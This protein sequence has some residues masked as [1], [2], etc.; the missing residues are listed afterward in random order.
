M[1]EILGEHSEKFI[2]LG[3]ILSKGNVGKKSGAETER[4]AIQRPLHLGIHPICRHQAQTL[5]LMPRSTLQTVACYS[6]PLR[7]SA[8]MGTPM[9][10]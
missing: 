9:E 7:G 8:S 3:L 4:E 2:N 10:E 1:V 6:C 5:L